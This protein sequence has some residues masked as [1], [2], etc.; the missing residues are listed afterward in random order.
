MHIRPVSSRCAWY[1]IQPPKTVKL[2]FLMLVH[3][4]F[5]WVIF[6]FRGGWFGLCSVAGI[7]CVDEAG[8]S[9]PCSKSHLW[10]LCSRSWNG[11]SLPFFM[12]RITVG[13]GQ[14]TFHLKSVV[15]SVSWSYVPWGG[16][17]PS[18]SGRVSLHYPLY[19]QNYC[20]RR[21]NS[22]HLAEV[23]GVCPHVN[24]HSCEMPLC[25]NV[26]PLSLQT[27]RPSCNSG[28]HPFPSAFRDIPI[29]ICVQV[30]SV[31]RCVT[32]AQKCHI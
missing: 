31:S 20:E 26:P 19:P 15:R 14:W 4:T 9:S 27:E 8:K 3:I 6:I 25:L 28:H 32:V 16:E 18:S 10:L 17:H 22:H 1:P 23:V 7:P 13:S 2:P 11:F 5:W 12:F 30:R 29:P 21:C 24:A